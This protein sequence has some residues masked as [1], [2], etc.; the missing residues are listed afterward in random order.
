MKKETKKRNIEITSILN[1]I[2][3]KVWACKDS[4]ACKT[5]IIDY[6]TASEINQKDKDAITSTVRSKRNIN[7]VHMYFANSLLQYEGLGVIK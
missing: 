1:G 3:D 4:D 6:V 2:R 7:E 5:L